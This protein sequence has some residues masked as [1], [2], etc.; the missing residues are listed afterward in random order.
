MI[1]RR[2]WPVK[3]DETKIGKVYGDEGDT[4]R[5]IKLRVQDQLGIPAS[6]VSVTRRQQQYYGG[7]PV[8]VPDDK[9]MASEYSISIMC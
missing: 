9:K 5:V 6:R 4:V 1:T 7:G 2:C 3:R 8:G